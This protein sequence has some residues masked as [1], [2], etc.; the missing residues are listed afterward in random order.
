MVLLLGFSSKDLAWGA[1]TYAKTYRTHLA[2]GGSYGGAR[3]YPQPQQH[4]CNTMPVD[5]TTVS[6]RMQ[7][8]R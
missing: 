2:S 7:H 5:A 6:Q 4:L 8:P 3:M 1:V